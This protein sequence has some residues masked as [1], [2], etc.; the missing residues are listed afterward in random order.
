MS[1]LSAITYAVLLA[2]GNFA[3]AGLISGDYAAA[4]ERSY[5]QAWALVSFALWCHFVLRKLRS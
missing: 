1:V 4:H 2:L 3:Y 5:F